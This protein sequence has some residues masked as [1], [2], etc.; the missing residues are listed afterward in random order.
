M[1]A[2]PPPAV[3]PLLL[4]DALVSV[5]S[6]VEEF[7]TMSSRGF[8]A[9]EQRPV[10]PWSALAVVAADLVDDDEDRDGASEPIAE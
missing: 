2:V 8:D 1:D 4:D 7:C 9:R 3:P 5:L 10:T 6:S